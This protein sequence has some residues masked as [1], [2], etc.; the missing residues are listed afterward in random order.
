M[1]ELIAL[2][3][4]IGAIGL[5]IIYSSLSWGFVSFK[6]YGWF[7]L[8][9]IPTLPES[10]VI[11]FMGIFLF[12]NCLIRGGSSAQIKDEYKDNLGTIST[13]LISPWVTFIIGWLIHLWF[14]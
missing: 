8:S 11:Q 14:F 6:F 9:S 5:F 4:I 2:L 13:A 3:L 12:L 1:E 7:I 10:N